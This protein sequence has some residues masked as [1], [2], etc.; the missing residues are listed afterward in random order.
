[1]TQ[2]PQ[3]EQLKSKVFSKSQ[4]GDALTYAL[5]MAREFNCVESLLGRDFEVLDPDGN[6]VFRIRQ[7]PLA[8][9][10]LNE[11]MKQFITIRKIEEAE[12]KKANRGRR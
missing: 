10:Q 11:L 3:L 1:M 8:F 12:Q 6:L 9:K 2:I 5:A 4:K 7:K